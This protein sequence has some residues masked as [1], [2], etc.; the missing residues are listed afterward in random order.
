MTALNIA[1]S[2]NSNVLYI[3]TLGSFS[4]KRV[5]QILRENNQYNEEQKNDY[6]KILSKIHCSKVYDIFQLIQLLEEFLLDLENHVNP[7]FFFFLK[8]IQ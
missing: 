6:E 3:D 4:S 1:A 2:T 7:F 8:S 5:L